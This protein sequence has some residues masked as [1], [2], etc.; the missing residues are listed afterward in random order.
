[1]TSTVQPDDLDGLLAAHA[2]GA[3]DGNELE[4]VER[5]LAADGAARRELARYARATD[6]LD[7]NAGPRPEV[8]DNIAKAIGDTSGRQA[9]VT[10][11]GAARR[12]RAR[13]ARRV[14][15]TI[16]I[17]AAIGVVVAATAWGVEQ[18]DP[19][20]SSARPDVGRDARAAANAHGARR[21]VL[22]TGDGTSATLVL[23]PNGLGYVLH[24]N[25][26]VALHGS[27]YRLFGTTDH[28]DVELA[29]IGRRIDATVFHL[30]T[31]VTALVL[32]RGTA[33][34]SR[35]LAS[36]PV[37]VSV[38]GTSTPA[39]TNGGVTAT[40]P[41]TSVA[42]PLVPPTTLLPGLPGLP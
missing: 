14:V 9:V 21:V 2:L 28:G 27:A 19:S 26:P 23:L 24:G 13:G 39:P 22:R 10:P 11:I 29:V 8:W 12:P 16:G 40:A 31:S 20:S 7:H 15:R 1:M 41:G 25:L 32:E 6:L 17:A 4:V 34:S 5:A 30:P 36:Q 42:R 18:V 35:R 37:K 33:T 3:L 38:G